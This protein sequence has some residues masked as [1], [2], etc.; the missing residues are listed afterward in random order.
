MLTLQK[1]TNSQLA[2]ETMLGR[3][4]SYPFV[5]GLFFKGLLLLVVGSVIGV[6]GWFGGVI[7]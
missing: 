2:P 6:L 7:P 5:D 1:L 3:G 4:V